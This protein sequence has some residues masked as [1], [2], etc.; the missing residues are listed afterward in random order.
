VILIF[1][2]AGALR[3]K[4]ISDK[5]REQVAQQLAL[6]KSQTA[7]A[8]ARKDKIVVNMAFFKKLFFLL[9][10]MIPGIFTS[11][12]GFLMLVAGSMVARTYCDVWMIK[13]GT[14]IERS[15]ISR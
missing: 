5:K 4:H 15:I 13:N 8:N 10:I 6:N 1:F 3:Q 12:F 11:E 14:A 9:K 2:I 7:Q